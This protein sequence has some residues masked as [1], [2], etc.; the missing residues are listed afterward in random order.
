MARMLKVRPTKIELVKLERRLALSQ[1]VKKILKDRLAILTSEFI[2]TARRAIVARERM[3]GAVRRASTAA[4]VAG[5]FHGA[6]AL[7]KSLLAS[8]G[9]VK[10]MAG[11]HNVAGAR[12]PVLEL[13]TP[14]RGLPVYDLAQTSSLVDDA[15]Q[16]GREAL[17]AIVAL[18]ALERTLELLGMEI[19]RT[20]RISNALEYLVVPSLERTIR[21]LSMKFEER[22][23]EEK[24]RLKHIKVMRAHSGVGPN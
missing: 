1:R 24:A 6:L 23:R 2:A 18:A 8:E 4:A 7:E 16:A 20:K 9:G 19:Q 10:V 15:A 12:V 17:G 14:A 22:D 5:G 13:E 11:T 3:A 21:S